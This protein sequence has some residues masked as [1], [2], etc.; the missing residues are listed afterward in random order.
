MTN[1]DRFSIDQKDSLIFQAVFFVMSLV[2]SLLDKMLRPKKALL[3]RDGC[4]KSG[5]FDA[6]KGVGG[7]VEVYGKIE[8]QTAEHGI[9][10]VR[11]FG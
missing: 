8:K 2:M 1:I 6:N 4:I 7:Y 11:L 9:F 10:R 3:W 5:N